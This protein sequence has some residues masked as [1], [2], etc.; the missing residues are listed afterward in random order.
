MRKIINNYKTIFCYRQCLCRQWVQ[1][2][3]CVEA[4]MSY[5]KSWCSWQDV[6]H[7]LSFRL[8]MRYTTYLSWWQHWLVLGCAHHFEVW[9]SSSFQH[10]LVSN[11]IANPRQISHQACLGL[12]LFCWKIHNI[13]L[14]LQHNSES[15]WGIIPS[16][17]GHTL[18]S[19]ETIVAHQTKLWDGQQIVSQFSTQ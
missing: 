9:L 11:A 16:S 18:I 8:G 2:N 15:N 10:E 6:E 7:Q 14:A 12:N 3:P 5:L 13:D 4:S 17:D 19:K 1:T